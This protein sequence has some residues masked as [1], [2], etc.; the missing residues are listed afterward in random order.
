MTVV[1]TANQMFRHFL[2]NVHVLDVKLP[3]DLLDL[4]HVKFIDQRRL[5]DQS[6]QRGA[7]AATMDSVDVA[8][9]VCLIKMSDFRF[10][11]QNYWSQNS[12]YF[13]WDS[14]KNYTFNDDEM[15]C[16]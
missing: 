1:W 12:S 7:L 16:I 9:F 8:T 10:P 14:V 6:K 5:Y 15:R 11:V 2:R 13:F 3:R 4:D